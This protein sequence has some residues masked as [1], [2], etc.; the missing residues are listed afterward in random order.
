MLPAILTNTVNSSASAS[1]LK[2]ASIERSTRDGFLIGT[3]EVSRVRIGEMETVLNS[4]FRQVGTLNVCVVLLFER[5]KEGFVLS[6][7]LFNSSDSPPPFDLFKTFVKR[8]IFRE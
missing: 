6:A 8:R 2:T 4:T 1:Y 3:T 7:L 5:F